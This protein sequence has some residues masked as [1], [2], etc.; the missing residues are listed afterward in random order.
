MGREGVT[1]RG[2]SVGEFFERI[3]KRS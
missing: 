3:F 2:G 1:G